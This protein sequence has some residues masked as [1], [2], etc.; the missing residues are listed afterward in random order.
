M[1]RSA[2]WLRVFDAL[3]PFA[4]DQEEAKQMT[5]A[6]MKAMKAPKKVKKILTVATPTCPYCF[7]SNVERNSIYPRWWSCHNCNRAFARRIP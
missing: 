7:S 3:T 5:I 1:S 4:S 2:Q 6:A